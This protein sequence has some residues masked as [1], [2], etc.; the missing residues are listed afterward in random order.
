MLA[1]AGLGFVFGLHKAR[2]LV[3]DPPLQQ[4]KQER[5]VVA[6][7]PGKVLVT[8]GY[9]VLDRAF[10]GLVL[11]VSARF[12]SLVSSRLP[13]PL[14]GSHQVRQGASPLQ[15]GSLQLVLSAPQRQAEAVLYRLVPE[16]ACEFDYSVQ[17]ISKDAE[18]NKFVEMTVRFTLLVIGTLI[19]RKAF[20]H[21][22]HAGGLYI[23][24]VGDEAFYSSKES[25]AEELLVR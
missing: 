5:G 16:N 4:T 11:G 8:G 3:I 23:R 19:G 21:C 25:T 15:K 17:K 2:H 18:S 24:L 7:A 1:L 22:V 13:A 6:S 14:T 12:H 20:D 9:L 10:S